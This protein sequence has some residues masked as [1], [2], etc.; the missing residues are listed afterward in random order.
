MHAWHKGN[1]TNFFL[2][3]KKKGIPIR[4]CVFFVAYQIGDTEILKTK[5]AKIC[6]SFGA[7]RYSLPSDL[8]T[9]DQVIK[10]KD[11][12]LKDIAEV[13]T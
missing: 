8:S 9:I 7:T 3:I 5:L 13:F 1:P 4:K 11:Q 6:E 2:K 12:E 10:N